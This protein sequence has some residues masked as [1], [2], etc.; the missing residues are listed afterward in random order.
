M[1]DT[2]SPTTASPTLDPTD[3]RAT[4]AR[5]V[6]LG[7]DVV[8]RITPDQ[9]GL[10][11]PCA[12]YTVRQLAGH[13]LGVLQ[14]VAI[15]GRGG[16]PFDAPEVVEGVADDGWHAAWTEAAHEIQTVWSDPA[17]LTTTVVLP[18]ATLDGAG[19]LDMYTAELTVHT[20]DLATA[21][22]QRVT[23]DDDVVAVALASIQPMLPAGGR[24]ERFAA[25]AERMGVDAGSFVPPY[26]EAVPVAAPAAPIDQLVAWTGRRP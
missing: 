21:T 24:A 13:V 1:N 22:G 26:L 10:P 23:F 18:W 7:R 19:L 14:R 5:S 25:A 3:P 6:A 2:T 12:A 17:L 20:W 8:A 15:L 4:F 11:T 16:D 9:L